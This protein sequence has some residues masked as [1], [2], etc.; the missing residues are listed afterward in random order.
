M[1]DFLQIFFGFLEG[2]SLR[3][4]APIFGVGN[5]ICSIGSSNHLY[6]SRAMYNTK[7]FL[8]KGVKCSFVINRK[9]SKLLEIIFNCKNAWMR[10]QERRSKQKGFF[11]S[12]PVIH[13]W[14][15]RSIILTLRMQ[16]SS[17]HLRLT[18]IQMWT[19]SRPIH[20]RLFERFVLITVIISLNGSKTRGLWWFYIVLNIVL[21]LSYFL[22]INSVREQS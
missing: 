19:L 6:W 5:N 11:T 2:V 17:L 13:L 12:F 8:P 10:W 9:L 21:S 4:I 14:W 15:I 3:I 18:M 20:A 22:F 16:W 7:I 1:T